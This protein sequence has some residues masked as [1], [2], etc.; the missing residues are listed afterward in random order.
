MIQGISGKHQTFFG[1]AGPK[2]SEAAGPKP[3]EAAGPK[4]SEARL[5]HISFGLIY[6]LIPS[7]ASFSLY[8]F[9]GRR[10]QNLIGPQ[11]P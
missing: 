1:A 2:P 6:D 7:E 10:P 5:V 9:W 11:A 3:S 4:P 8:N